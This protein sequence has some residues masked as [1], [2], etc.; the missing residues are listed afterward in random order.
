MTEEGYVV[1]AEGRV[2]SDR[3][4]GGVLHAVFCDVFVMRDTK[5]RHITS[6]LMEVAA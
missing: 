3:A 1:V 6:Y 2:R 4:D 5:I